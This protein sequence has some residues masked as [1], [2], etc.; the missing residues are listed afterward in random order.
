MTLS[1]VS[2]PEMSRNAWKHYLYNSVDG[3][4]LRHADQV[5]NVHGWLVSGTS[6]LSGAKFNA[7]V[8]LRAGVLPTRSRRSR[9]FPDAIKHCDSCGPGQIE[10]LAHVLQCCC[11][12]SGARIKRHDRL[13][14]LLA[15]MLKKLGWTVQVELR[16]ETSAGLR[17]PDL[18]AFKPGVSAWIIDATVVSENYT[19]LDTPHKSKI[20]YYGEVPEIKA[21]I[22]MQTGV[23]PSFTSLTLSWRGLYSPGSAADLSLLGLK[24]GDLEFLAAVCVEQGAIIHRIHQTATHRSWW[25]E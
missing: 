23:V 9:G 24:R 25:T 21:V 14:N 5:P 1:Q 16:I 20:Q 17:K 3:K 18:L 4:G 15:D 19:T 12:T 6:L 7:A 8:S 13:V 10:C 2:T 22:E 11:R